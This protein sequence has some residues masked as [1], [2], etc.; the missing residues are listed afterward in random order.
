MANL[1]PASN[2]CLSKSS[3]LAHFIGMKQQDS[4]NNLRENMHYQW[5]YG[6]VQPSNISSVLIFPHPLF[7]PI[8]CQRKSSIVCTLD[9][10]VIPCDLS[11][12]WANS[13]GSSIGWLENTRIST[14]PFFLRTCM[15]IR[16]CDCYSRVH[17]SPPFGLFMK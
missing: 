5:L 17:N 10:V 13:Y 8:F 7:S 4:I 1:N 6:Y 9:T 16:K 14:Q 15:C 3:L 12:S 11:R 2:P